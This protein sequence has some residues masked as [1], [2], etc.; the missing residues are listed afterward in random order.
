GS[1]LARYFTSVN[2][3]DDVGVVPWNWAKKLGARANLDL[4]I[5]NKLKI[6]AGMGYLRNRTRLAQGGIDIDPFSNL[7]WGNPL[8]LTKGQRGFNTS[9][10]E[11][12]STV[13]SHADVDRTTTNLAVNYTPISWF[14]NRLIAG[15]DASTENDWM[16]YPRQ[17][18]GNLDFLGNNGLGSK[19]VARV[20]HN[21]I[22]LDYSGAAKYHSDVLQFPGDSDHDG[23]RRNDAHWLRDVYRERDSR[24]VRPGG[25]GMAQSPLPYC[26]S[27]RRRQQCIRQAVQGRI[28]PE[29]QRLM[30]HRRGAMVPCSG[31]EQSAVARGVRCV[32][33]PARR[34]RRL[35]TV[36]AVGRRSGSTRSRTER[37]RK[38]RTTSGA[39]QGTR[40][41]LREHR[42]RRLDGHQLHALSSQ[43]HGRHRELAFATVDGIPRLPGCQYRSSHGM[44]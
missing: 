25:D 12:W 16:L 22:T 27:P 3:D 19:S 28:L 32:R 30:G 8:T 23:Q 31:R 5:S 7:I 18:K 40:T 6:T 41:G 15:L 39:Q 34:L 2:Y 43:H 14:T 24:C 13:E 42:Y 4:L 37:I 1:D 9:P 38:S 10:P 29:I 36:C 44:G 20:L 33:H 21:F 26:R 17:P 11:E 35:A